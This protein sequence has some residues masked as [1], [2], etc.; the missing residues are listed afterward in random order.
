MSAQTRPAAEPASPRRSAVDVFNAR[1]LASAGK[2]ALRH[3]EGGAWKPTT[4][5]EWARAAREIAGGLADLAVAPGDRVAIL[6][7]TR[8]EWSLCDVGILT[9][10]AV[11]VPIYASSLP[12]Q[13]EYIL[14]DSSAVVAIVEDEK[15]LEKLVAVRAALPGL[16][17]VV[18]MSGGKSSDWVVTLDELRASGA[19]WL[20][21]NPKRLDDDVAGA[22]DPTAAATIIYTSGTTGPPKG[23]IITHGN[24][25]FACEAAERLLGLGDGDEQLLFLPL[26]HSFARMV[27][28]A[29]ISIGAATA[30]AQNMNTLVADMAEV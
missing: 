5:T 28:W 30:F 9:A 27:E 21:K 17:K 4:W 16:R 20:E 7:A 18:V 1:A 2:V 3:K 15:Q 12:D 22:I 11:V 6:A 26:A 19:R 25:V 13:C 14:S 10:G 29:F 24:L 23:V 8:R